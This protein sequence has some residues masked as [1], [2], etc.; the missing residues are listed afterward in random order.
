MKLWYSPRSPYAR[1]CRIVAIERGIAD[2]L[3]LV[4]ADLADPKSAGA[5]PNPLGKVPAL[6][7]DDGTLIIDSP[8][9]AEHLDQVPGLAHLVP[10]EGPARRNATQLEAIADGICDAVVLANLERNRREGERSE[11]VRNQQLAKVERG[12][13]LLEREVARLDGPV[14]IGHIALGCMLGYH[15]FRFG[16]D[17]RKTRP[18]LASWYD[19]FAARPSMRETMPPEMKSA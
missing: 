4:A 6:L 8:L 17:W 16:S 12:L 3:E 7:L 15:E 18:R 14:T 9:I 10:M 11:T 1:K 13:D 19:G 5:I 2:R